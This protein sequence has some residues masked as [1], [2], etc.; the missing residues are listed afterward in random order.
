MISILP[1]LHSF[2]NLDRISDCCAFEALVKQK[3]M[4]G[5]HRYGACN[6]FQRP[7]VIF[8]LHK[9]N[10]TAVRDLNII[11][12]EIIGNFSVFISDTMS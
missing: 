8:K 7:Y 5:R 9:V 6:V 1:G 3:F 11:L 4:K 2:D 10:V 12:A